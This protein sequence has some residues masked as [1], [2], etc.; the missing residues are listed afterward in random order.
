MGEEGAAG[1][2]DQ[3]RVPHDELQDVHEVGGGAS[4]LM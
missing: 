1:A 4:F 2:V 3:L